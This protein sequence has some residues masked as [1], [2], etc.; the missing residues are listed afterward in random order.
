[1]A[2][3]DRNG[4]PPRTRRPPHCQFT[5]SLDRQVRPTVEAIARRAYERFKNRARLTDWI[6]TTGSRRGR[7]ARRAVWGFAAAHAPGGAGG[8]AHSR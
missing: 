4:D 7:P 2:N 6:S 8:A 1:M 5:R 3:D